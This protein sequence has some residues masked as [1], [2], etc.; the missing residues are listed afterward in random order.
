MDQKNG[1]AG[2]NLVNSSAFLTLSNP[3]DFVIDDELAHK[4]L[5]QLGWQV[6]DVPWTQTERAWSDFDAVIIRS[7]WD[8][9]EQPEAFLA[10]LEEIDAGPACLANPLDIVRWNLSKTYLKSL[11]DGDVPIVPTLWGNQIAAGDFTDFLQMF[12]S[13]ELVIKPVV[14]AN[15]VDAFRVTAQ[16]TSNRLEE[17]AICHDGRAF[18]VQ[19]FIPSII[20]EGEYSVFYFNGLFSHAILKTPAPGEFRSQEERGSSLMAIQ[21]EPGLLARANQA[22]EFISSLTSETLLYARLDFVRDASDDFVVMEAELIE[23]SL[24]L[25]MDDGAPERFARA[26]DDWFSA[27]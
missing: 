6:T 22:M 16:E 23:P 10:V 11:H 21:P 2:Q 17:I 19:P 1:V 20:T 24:Y 12:D 15:G 7:P 27:R 18:M 5:A 13:E 9:P 8:Y 3:A 4:P 14:G 25:R 26:I